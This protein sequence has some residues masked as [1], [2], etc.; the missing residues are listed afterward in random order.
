MRNQSPQP[1]T[2]WTRDPE[3]GEETTTTYTERLPLP[4]PGTN[5]SSQTTSNDDADASSGDDYSTGDGY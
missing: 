5:R 2:V 1:V 3:T 4:D